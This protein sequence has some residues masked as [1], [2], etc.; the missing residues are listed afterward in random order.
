[1]YESNSN[2]RVIN[3]DGRALA[4]AGA[5]AGLI[6]GL[7]MILS[8]MV[9]TAAIGEGFLFPAKE[10]AATFMGVE[11]IIGGVGTVLLGLAIHLAVSA[12][13]GAAFSLMLAPNSSTGSAIGWGIAYAVGIWLVMTYV[14]LPFFDPVMSDRVA[15]YSGWWFALHLVYGAVLGITPELA[16]RMAVREVYTDTFRRAA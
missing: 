7:V 15:L 14:A 1:M 2:W 16:E 9:Y 5:E 6:S 11:A 12:A 13:W 10:I 4:I 8:M 3:G